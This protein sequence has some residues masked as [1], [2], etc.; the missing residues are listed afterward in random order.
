VIKI[1]ILHDVHNRSMP[2]DK[3]TRPTIIETLHGKNSLLID[4]IVVTQWT[5]GDFAIGRPDRVAH[6]PQ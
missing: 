1:E 4:E 5:Y 3:S 6:G 2:A